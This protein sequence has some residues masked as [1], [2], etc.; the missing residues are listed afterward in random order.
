MSP[1]AAIGA[2][3]LTLALASCGGGSHVERRAHGV[4][5]EAARG[6]AERLPTANRTAFY[7]LATVDGLVRARAVVARTH[8][9][10]SI[11]P[12]G[13]ADAQQRLSIL[14]PADPGLRALRGELAGALTGVIRKGLGAARAALTVC[15]RVYIGLLRY[16]HTHPQVVGLIPD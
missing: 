8:G 12:T 11:S 15:D 4:G 1:R 5:E 2:A 16:Q 9:P 13:L 10:T 6:A 14:S 3:S 7:Q